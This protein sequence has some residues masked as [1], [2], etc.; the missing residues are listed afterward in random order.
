ML[1]TL[2][3]AIAVLGAVVLLC[4]LRVAQRLLRPVALAG[5]MTLTIYSAHVFV[6]AWVSTEDLLALWLGLVVGAL[7]F[8]VLWS[9]WVGQGP[10]ER[11][12]AIPADRARRAVLARDQA[13]SG[14][15]RP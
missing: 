15:R 2:G 8:A 12:V 5:A 13:P 9:R 6:L 4:R 10:L 11:L 7:V 1:S 14:P 3:S